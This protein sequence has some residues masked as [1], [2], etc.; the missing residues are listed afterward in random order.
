MSFLYASVLLFPPCKSTITQHSTQV[1]SQTRPSKRL[2]PSKR[3]QATESWLHSAIADRLGPILLCLFLG[4]LCA[5][6]PT[7]S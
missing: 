7:R 2:R 3:I 6:I 5:S 4:M 1:F